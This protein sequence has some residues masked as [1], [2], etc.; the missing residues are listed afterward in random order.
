MIRH[1]HFLILLALLCSAPSLGSQSGRTGLQD[2]A[3]RRFDPGAKKRVGGGVEV[4][5]KSYLGRPVAKTMH[6]R[7]AGWL[8]RDHRNREE[9]TETLLDNLRIEPGQVVGDL[10]CGNGYLSLPIASRVGPRGRVFAADLQPEML[11]LLRERAAHKNI[12]NIQTLQS[13]AS[14]PGFAPGSCDWILMVDVYHELDRPES[15]LAAVRRALRPGG[16]LALVEFRAEDPS[17]KI[18]P[19][20][21]MTKA[22][23]LG[24]MAYNGLRFESEFNGL[25]WQHLMW[26][27]VE[28]GEFDP[29]ALQAR[30]RTAGIAMAKGAA[31]A[32]LADDG[33]SLR[34]FLSPHAAGRGVWVGRLDRHFDPRTFGGD[35]W[36]LEFSIQTVE[37]GPGQVRLWCSTVAGDLV[38]RMSSV[39]GALWHFQDLGFVP[40]LRR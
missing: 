14:D 2:Q 32:W 21:K 6:W 23:I 11:K 34:A 5:R 33:R 37:P 3:P 16:R 13:S 40:V 8:I 31:R 36:N 39:D 17:V 9:G 22:Q 28:P 27:V 20:H 7:G 4:P 18:K 19:E 15:V 30:K 12:V 35:G 1:P 24:E 26:F 10:G 25:P 29:R 38:G